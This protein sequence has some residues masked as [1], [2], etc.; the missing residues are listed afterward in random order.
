MIKNKLLGVAVFSAFL[1]SSAM[2]ENT[3]ST[4]DF[5]L[6]GIEGSYSTISSDIDD[7]TT[8]PA[9][10]STNRDNVSGIGL[11]IGAQ[12][13]S[14]R[15]LL[16]ANYYNNGNGNYDYIGTYGGQFDYLLNVSDK[17]NVYLG[18]NAGMFNMKY[19]VA[20]ENFGRI[21]ANPYYGGDAGVNVHITP[22]VDFEVGARMMLLNA[23]NTKNNVTYTFNNMF[24]GYASIIFKYQMD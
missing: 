23:S 2:A 19:T 12:S 18:V 5:S 13:D 15:I 22:L 21:I 8:T 9:S 20:N 14:Y 1:A 16:T 3:L 24:T 7:K 6:I 11:K 10:Y 4:H 17:F